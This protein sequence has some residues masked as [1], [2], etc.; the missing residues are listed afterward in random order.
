MFSTGTTCTSAFADGHVS[1]AA[2][3]WLL[4]ALA[5]PKDEA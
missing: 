5:L 4:I 1:N 2:T 3:T